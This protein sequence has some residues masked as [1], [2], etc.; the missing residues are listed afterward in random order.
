MTAS[1]RSGAGR[2]AR[3]TAWSGVLLLLAVPAAHALD[4]YIV[5]HAETMGNVTLDY[6]EINQNTLS[7]KGLQ[8]VAALPAKLEG[9]KFDEILV[10]PAWRTQKTILPY[11]EKNDRKAEICPEIEELDCNITGKEVASLDIPAG[12]HVDIADNAT[13]RFFF[14]EASAETHFAP[15]NREES[16]G[17]LQ[18]AKNLVLDR[19][20]GKDVSVLL[21]THSCTGGRF[22]ELMLGLRPKGAFS[23]ANAS[24][25]HLVQKPDGS[26]DIVQ[27]NDAPLTPLQR[28]GMMGYSA[29]L[30]PGFKSLEGA[31]KIA[32]GDDM[33]RAAP[34]FDDGNFL[35]TSVPG[36]WE[37]DVLPD[38]D[39]VAWYRLRFNISDEQRAAW[40]DVTLALVMG[41]IDDAD[42]TFLN[43]Q[44]IGA[45]GK[46]SPVRETAWD[47]VRAY[48]FSPALL[49][50]GENVIAI[51]VDD[52]GGGGGIWRGPVAIG[53]AAALKMLGK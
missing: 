23:P 7:P 53:P 14:R 16:L 4:I 17:V 27:Y 42:E 40:G 37:R 24:V 12:P 34:E 30:L 25:T 36:G 32:R 9:L 48:E 15:R 45:S 50:Q 39:G 44:K 43:G 13:N 3:I 11:L 29:D 35:T 6:S 31:W 20:G 2:R 33:A 28:M 21:V 19:F 46:L 52:W 41:A 8:Q 49:L 18:R 38:Y 1:S 47:Q 5:R 10:S 51:R 22:I 26:F